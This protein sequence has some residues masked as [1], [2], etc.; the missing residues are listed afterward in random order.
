MPIAG[1]GVKLPVELLA[2]GLANGADHDRPF[3]FVR[4]K[5]RGHDL[6]FCGHI[7]IGVH[8]LT[9]VATGI[10]DVGAVGG[11]VESSGARTVRRE[12]SN[13]PRSCTFIGGGV[14]TL[15][16]HATRKCHTGHNLDVFSGVLAHDSN[17]L[18]DMLVNQRRLL[19]G[20]G[21][22]NLR[23]GG[24]DNHS[25]GL[26]AGFEPDSSN[27]TL[28]VRA[29]D[30]VFGFPSGETVSFHE[31]RVGGGRNGGEDEITFG[32]ANCR[33]HV[34]ARIILKSYVGIRDDRAGRVKHRS[35]QRGASRLRKRCWLE[36]QDKSKK[37]RGQNGDR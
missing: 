1:I 13:W 15:I 20:V 7:R 19:A 28:V 25:F 8:G 35:G 6:E 10:N 36:W 12:A 2:A 22:S 4:A 31:H 27:V 34:A 26:R 3:G 23:V 14:G 37:D 18:Q 11:N 29:K 17:V 9:A 16:D 5:V 33:S 21:R 30:D 24:F 32:V